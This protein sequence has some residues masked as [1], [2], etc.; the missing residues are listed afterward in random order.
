MNLG[1]QIL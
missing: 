1:P